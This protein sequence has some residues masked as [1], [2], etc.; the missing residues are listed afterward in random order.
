MDDIYAWSTVQIQQKALWSNLRLLEHRYSM[1]QFSYVHTLGLHQAMASFLLFTF[2]HKWNLFFL[3]C[4]ICGT[5]TH[6]HTHRHLIW[7][8][9]TQKAKTQAHIH[10]LSQISGADSNFMI[11][12]K[13][14][15]AFWKCF[16][17]PTLNQMFWKHCPWRAVWLLVGIFG[18][19]NIK[20]SD[21]LCHWNVF[22]PTRIK[23]TP[24]SMA[25]RSL[26][27][28]PIWILTRCRVWIWYVV[29]MSD[30]LLST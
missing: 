3:Y 30:Q 5:G 9:N 18:V 20:S 8:W 23:E 16:Y 4:I 26:N 13:L 27:V 1:Y 2:P 25:N 15:C 22:I 12:E 29:Q 17:I 19:F 21:S 6:I 11:A 24:L 10:F 28:N 14:P 7:K